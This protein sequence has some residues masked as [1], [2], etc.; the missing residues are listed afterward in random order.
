MEGT[1]SFDCPAHA[2]SGRRRSQTFSRHAPTRWGRFKVADDDP[3]QK[4]EKSKSGLHVNDRRSHSY[5]SP[6]AG[7]TRGSL[8]WEGDRSFA[9][10]T[11]FFNWLWRENRPCWFASG[12]MRFWVPRNDVLFTRSVAADQR[13]LLEM[14][15]T[16]SS[17]REIF[18]ARERVLAE[19]E[20]EVSD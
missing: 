7:F 2:S 8:F 10:D 4:S 14:G 6:H 20:G 5:P 19:G 17:E 9:A 3:L 18:R 16:C 11:A 13:R 15:A 12:A 1:D